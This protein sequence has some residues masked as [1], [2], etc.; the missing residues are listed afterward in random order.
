MKVERT[1]LS[2]NSSSTQRTGTLH[3]RRVE[4]S[5]DLS[6]NDSDQLPRHKKDDADDENQTPV[7]DGKERAAGDPNRTL[8]IT[9]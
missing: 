4:A 6:H 8:N 5:S 7:S 9:A 1:Q 3:S 2:L